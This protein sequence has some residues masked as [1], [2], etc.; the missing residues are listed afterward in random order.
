MRTVTLKLSEHL[1]C[2]L[3]ALAKRQRTTRAQVLRGALEAFIAHS[4]PLTFSELA[5]D[6]I[7]DDG[8]GDLSTSPN[9][10][11]GYGR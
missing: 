9:F 10:L 6:L 3:T 2:R 4:P 1:D 11:D 8:P 7:I 5:A